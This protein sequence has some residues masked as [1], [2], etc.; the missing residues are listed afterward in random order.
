MKKAGVV[1]TLLPGVTLFLQL[2]KKPNLRA[3]RETK[4]HVAIASDYNPGSC[5]IYSMP[6]IIALACL[7]YGMSVENALIGATKNGAKALKLYKKIGS[8][9]PNKQAD[10]VVLGVDNYKKIPYYF[11][12]DIVR[13]TIKKGR[14]IYGKNR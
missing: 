5:M 11:G 2:S 4:S 9:E 14:I 10:I 7:I 12:E 13:Y 8:I 6:K 3:F 1:P